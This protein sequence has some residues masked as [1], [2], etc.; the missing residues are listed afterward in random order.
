M[1]ICKMNLCS[2]FLRP[3]SVVPSSV[4]KLYT[5]QNSSIRS[6]AHRGPVLWNILISKDKNFS[7]TSYKNLKRE[8]PSMAFL[9]S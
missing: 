5:T 6:I 1:P 2:R 3:R 4:F 8:T 7:N 9:K